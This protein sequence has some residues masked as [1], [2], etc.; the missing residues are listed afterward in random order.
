MPRIGLDQPQQ[1]ADGGGFPLPV[2]AEERE[3]LPRRNDHVDATENL[4]PAEGFFDAGHLDDGLVG[5]GGL[6]SGG[7]LRIG[8]WE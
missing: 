6:Q 7:A 5:H 8:S 4:L 1:R 2:S 3:G